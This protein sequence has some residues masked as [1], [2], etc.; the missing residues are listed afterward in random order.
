MPESLVDG[1]VE[2]DDRPLNCK[3]A[4]ADEPACEIKKSLDELSD[5]EPHGGE[6]A[7]QMHNLQNPEE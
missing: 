5:E 6:S 3:G 2:E 4:D 1:K 7:C